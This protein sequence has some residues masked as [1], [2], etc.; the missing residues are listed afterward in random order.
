MASPFR[1]FR[2]NAKVML[3]FFV[4]LLMFTWVIGDSLFNY[5]G[6]NRNPG[7]GNR[8]QA[9]AVAVQWMAAI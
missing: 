5:F 6:G 4:V 2:K 1:Y 3:A 8:L 9:G 7:G